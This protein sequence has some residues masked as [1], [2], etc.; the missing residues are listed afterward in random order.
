MIVFERDGWRCVKNTSSCVSEINCHH[1]EGIQKN[2]IESADADI[3]ITLC[4]NC[5]K[6]VHM[7][8]GCKYYQMGCLV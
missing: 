6:A 8:E 5:H 3:C 4:I 1:I 7:Q 2:T